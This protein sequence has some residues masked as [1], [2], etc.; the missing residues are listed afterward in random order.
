M[1]ETNSHACGVDN[2]ASPVHPHSKPFR[3]DDDGP[4]VLQFP[5]LF[6]EWVSSAERYWV[7]LAKHRSPFGAREK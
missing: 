7:I 3:V 1:M 6:S 2:N 5:V 4:S